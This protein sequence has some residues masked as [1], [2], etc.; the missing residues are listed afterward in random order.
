M[1]AYYTGFGDLGLENAVSFETNMLEA[2]WLWNI[3]P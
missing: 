3:F 1:P 2:A